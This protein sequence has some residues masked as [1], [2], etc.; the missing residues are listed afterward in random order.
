MSRVKEARRVL[1]EAALLL[2]V[3]ALDLGLSWDKESA[4]AAGT[5]A[6]PWIVGVLAL[7]LLARR[8]WPLGVLVAV[9]LGT[10]LVAGAVPGFVPVFCTWTALFSVATRCPRA[11]AATGLCLSGTLVALVAVSEAA[12]PGPG[13]ALRLATAVAAGLVALCAVFG[14]GR[15]VRWSVRQRSLVAEYAARAAT[16]AERSRIARDLHDVVAHGVS[17]MVLQ[18]S[19]AAQTAQKDPERAAAA[20]DNVVGLGQQAVAELRQMLGL[21]GETAAPAEAPVTAEWPPAE[22]LG[23]PPHRGRRLVQAEELV[24]AGCRAGL[25]LRLIQTGRP[26]S[27]RP[28]AEE[29]AY[30]VI[31]EAITNAAKHADAAS[32]VTLQLSWSTEGLVLRLTNEPGETEIGQLLSTGHGIAGMEARAAAAGGS[33]HA[34][35]SSDGFTVEASFPAAVPAAARRAGRAASARRLADA[36]PAA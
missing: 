13:G 17:L 22:G 36:L 28:E 9:L 4:P 7:P 1:V 5:A 32:P 27:L 21:L 24:R 11:A 31:Q 3:V 6:V 20:L 15:W 16:S 23:P 26:V 14:V 35:L 33:L 12:G 10:V 29:A 18:A 34:G 25:R 30:R 19:V 2:T 8:R